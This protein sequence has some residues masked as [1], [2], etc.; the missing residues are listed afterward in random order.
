MF[1][2]DTCG[3]IVMPEKQGISVTK[4][5]WRCWQSGQYIAFVEC[6]FTS[7]AFVSRA[8][9]AL[10]VSVALTDRQ[11]QAL[12][13]PNYR[14]LDPQQPFQKPPFVERFIVAENARIIWVDQA[15]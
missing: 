10:S 3:V 6:D 14:W 4:C 5:T 11:V 12:H 1:Q 2:P 15:S 8:C 7:S 9:F 13:A